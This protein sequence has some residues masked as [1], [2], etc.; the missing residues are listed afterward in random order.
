MVLRLRTD[1]CT[2]AAFS[3]F[4]TSQHLHQID[5]QLPAIKYQMSNKEMQTSCFS[6]AVVAHG[7]DVRTVL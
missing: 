6:S 1:P 2:R 7:I 5:H 4:L 3:F